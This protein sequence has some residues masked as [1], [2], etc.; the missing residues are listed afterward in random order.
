MSSDK[1]ITLNLHILTK[2]LI[3]DAQLTD[4]SEISAN[5]ETFIYTLL[6]IRLTPPLYKTD[7][8]P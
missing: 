2:S 8:H 5:S 6:S 1:V 4:I 7:L 3:V